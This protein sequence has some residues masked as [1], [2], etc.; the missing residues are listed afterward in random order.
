[1][2][3]CHDEPKKSEQPKAMATSEHNHSDHSHHGHSGHSGHEGMI[4]N[5]TKRFWISL[6]LAIPILL[7]LVLLQSVFS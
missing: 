5:F 3:C 1:M 7:F 2:E 4:A 6:A